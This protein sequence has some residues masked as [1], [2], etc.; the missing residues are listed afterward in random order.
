MYLFVLMLVPICVRDACMF[1]SILVHADV[2]ASRCMRERACVS[3]SVHVHL[4]VLMQTYVRARVRTC[5]LVRNNFER[6]R[7]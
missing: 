5:L 3:A 7:S 2:Y 1:V 4:C 6:A